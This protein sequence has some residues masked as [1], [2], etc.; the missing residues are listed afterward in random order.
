[1]A[2][3]ALNAADR[4]IISELRKGRNVPA[5]VAKATDYSRQ[6]VYDRLRRLA[7]HGVATNIGNGVYEL[8]ESEVPTGDV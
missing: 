4:A 6:Y 5:N 7:E 3:I 8:V 1:M 2:Q